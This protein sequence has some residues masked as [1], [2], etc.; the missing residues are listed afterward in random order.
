MLMTRHYATGTVSVAAGGTTVTGA[1][2][3]WAGAIRAGDVLWIAGITCRI[4]SVNSAT[5]LTLARPWP[6]PA[7]SGAAYEVWLTP[8]DVLY[9]EATRQ[10][11]DMLDEGAL[12]ALSGVSM[13]V[14]RVPY[15]DGPGTAATATLTA[16]ARAILGLSGAVG[17]A[18]I[19]VVTGT[20]TAALRDIV[21][22]AAQ[23]GG[24]PAGALI[25]TGSNSNGAYWRFAGGL[26]LCVVGERSVSHNGAD[27]NQLRGSW[28]YALPFSA[29]P[30]VFWSLNPARQTPGNVDRARL[31]NIW[32]ESFTTGV[33]L[34]ALKQQSAAAWAAGDVLSG[35]DLVAVG[36]W[37]A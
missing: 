14:D 1:G 30:A 27:N 12:S 11:I 20:G 33:N 15:F 4:A 37:H 17:A 3:G 34:Y 35:I 28:S 31:A 7:A 22:V 8:D 19:P 23:S 9:G 6:G 29:V 2:T 26:Q 24:V 13:A 36:R 32:T 25:E 10:L 21:G 5:S 16:A 18:K